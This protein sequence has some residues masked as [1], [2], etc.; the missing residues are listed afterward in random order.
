V[1]SEKTDGVGSIL[2]T[3]GSKT[4]GTPF[5]GGGGGGS[6]GTQSNLHLGLNIRNGTIDFLNQYAPARSGRAFA[7]AKINGAAQIA[8]GSI[9]HGRLDAVLISAGHRRPIV[10]SFIENDI[11]RLAQLRASVRDLPL[12]PIMNYFISST[13]FVIED[14]AADA[15]VHAYDVQWPDGTGPRW[16]ISAKGFFYNGRLRV[17]PLIVPVRNLNGPFAFGS[18][19]LALP[20][21]SGVAAQLP[22]LAHGVIALQPSP[23]LDLRVATSGPLAKARALLAKAHLRVQR[24]RLDHAHGVQD[25]RPELKAYPSPAVR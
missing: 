25:R 5:G 24:A 15:L 16:S 21:V 17:M 7:V 12:G 13:A 20:G 9:S 18:D 23:W 1:Y 6:A 19:V 4:T 11:T 14:G 22:V 2:F 3:T 8:T 10:A